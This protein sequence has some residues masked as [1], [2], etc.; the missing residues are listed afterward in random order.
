ML[1]GQETHHW[2]SMRARSSDGSDTSYFSSPSTSPCPVFSPQ[3]DDRTQLFYPSIPTFAVAAGYDRDEREQGGMPL[4][5]STRTTFLPTVESEYSLH[6]DASLD[7]LR[8]MREVS[9]SLYAEDSWKEQFGARD[10][11]HDAE[12]EQRSEFILGA[13]AGVATTAHRKTRMSVA[14]NSDDD[15]DDDTVSGGSPVKVQLT[16]IHQDTAISREQVSAKEEASILLAHVSSEC[17]NESQTN[18]N[19]SEEITSVDIEEL[20]RFIQNQVAVSIATPEKSATDFSQPKAALP[21]VLDLSQSDSKSGSQA[22]RILP[23]SG[24]RRKESFHGHRALEKLG[25]TP[26]DEAQPFAGSSRPKTPKHR[27]HARIWLASYFTKHPLWF[28]DYFD[29]KHLTDR[30]INLEQD[31]ERPLDFLKQDNLAMRRRMYADPMPGHLKPGGLFAGGPASP[32][33]MRMGKTRDW[34]KDEQTRKSTE[35]PCDRQTDQSSVSGNVI[36]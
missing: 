31:G 12:N 14:M 25:F 15:T 6:A 8:S 7:S 33:K 24:I 23:A 9:L 29:V 32:I 2:A 4:A 17:N 28:P 21:C 34:D 22:E 30:N 18:T 35:S 36:L 11:Q 27:S 16:T 20:K 1:H 5:I 3:N 19:E 26:C 13:R 10:P